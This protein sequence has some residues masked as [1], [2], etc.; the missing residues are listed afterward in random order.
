MPRYPIGST[1]I[2]G[3]SAKPIID[4]QAEVRTL[5]AGYLQG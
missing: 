1:A 3:L 5:E 4:L 2:L